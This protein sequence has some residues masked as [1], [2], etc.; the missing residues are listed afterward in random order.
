VRTFTL[1]W[2]GQMVSVIGS[3]MTDFAL[4]FWAWDLTREV[5]A[6]ALVRFFT[7]IPRALISLFAGVLVDRCN[8]KL[9]MLLGD[10]VAALSTIIVLVL[11]LTYQLNIVHLYL[12]GA[13]NGAFGQIQTL[14]YDASISQIVPKQHYTRASSMDSLLHYGSNIIAPALAAALYYSIGF[15][16]ILGIDVGTFVIAMSMLLFAN[17]PQPKLVKPSGFDIKALMQDL[18]FGFRYIFTRPSLLALLCIVSVFEFIHDLGAAVS[19]P[20]LLARTNSNAGILGSRA[21]AAGIGGV[22][23][24][25]IITLWSGPKRRIQG[26]LLGIVGAGLSK[27][28]FG[29]AQTPWIWIFTQFCSSLNFPLKDSCE[30]AIWL[31]KVSPDVQG[32]VFAARQMTQLIALPIAPILA[33]TLADRFLEPVMQPGG[34]LT[35]ILGGIF[36]EGPGA[37]MAL[38]YV[39]TS[40]GLCL[41]GLLGYTF[42]TLRNLEDQI[43]DHDPV[44]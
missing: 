10:T 28:A 30:Q 17:V 37:G 12:L 9:L 34:T 1:I 23:G 18:V 36:G 42:P 7:E 5:T 29:F 3:Y 43:P 31:A 2:L 24:A 41:L 19:T 33:G 26:L 8:R 14:A 44:L 25:L 27:M 15:A 20:M 22:V 38:L 40:S 21:S 6:L 13:L 35:P 16:G 11:Y 32:R 39:M 4:A